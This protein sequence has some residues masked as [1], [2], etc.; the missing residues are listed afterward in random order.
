[1]ENCEKKVNGVYCL[2]DEIKL[3]KGMVILNKVSYSN[4]KAL[5]N[6][7]NNDNNNKNNNGLGRHII[8]KILKM[9]QYLKM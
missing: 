3:C 8:I 9:N 7:N 6:K 4:L 1:M 5:Y 2:R